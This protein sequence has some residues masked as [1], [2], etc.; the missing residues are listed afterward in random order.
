[1]VVP[2]DVTLIYPLS[3]KKSNNV[4]LNVAVG[5]YGENYAK[6][7][8]IAYESRA[9]EDKVVANGTCGENAL[10]AL[11]TNG[12]MVISGSGAMDNYT[13]KDATPWADYLTKIKSVEIGKDITAIGKYAFAYATKIESITFEEGSKLEKIGAV[14]FIYTV[15]TEVSIPDT[16][17]YI[18]SMAFA[19][20]SHLLS[21]DVPQSVTFIHAQAFK[22]SSNVV[23]SVVDGT[24][25]ENYAIDNGVAYTVK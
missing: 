21:V 2:Q 22:K 7:N 9:Y 12:K 4:V 6:T 19:Y 23:L 20:C 11:Y 1:V 15:V 5:T 18:G 24:Y 25:A 17:T 14:A 13:G 8:G 16:V 3:F 10:W